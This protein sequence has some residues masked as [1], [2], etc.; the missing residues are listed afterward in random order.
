[1]AIISTLIVTA[2]VTAVMAAGA[3][4]YYATDGFGAGNKTKSSLDVQREREAAKLAEQAA[5][6]A[7]QAKRAEQFTRKTLVRNN[8]YYTP[9]KQKGLVNT[10]PSYATQP[11]PTSVTQPT[12]ATLPTLQTGY[13]WQEVSKEVYNT[14][15]QA[16]QTKPSQLFVDR[17]DTRANNGPVSAL[18]NTIG[19]RGNFLKDAG[20]PRWALALATLGLSEAYATTASF[21]DNYIWDIDGDG[22][23][24]MIK[25]IAVDPWIEVAEGDATWGQAL[26]GNALNTLN[27]FTEVFDILANPIKGIANNGWQGFLDSFGLGGNGYVVYDW[28]TGNF[29]LDLVAE[30]FSDPFTVVSALKGVANAGAK[31]AKSGVKEIGEQATK[32]VAEEATVRATKVHMKKASRAVAKQA[33]N[34]AEDAAQVTSKYTDDLLR[35]IYDN[36]Q[37]VVTKQGRELATKTATQVVTEGGKPVVKQVDLI[38]KVTNKVGRNAG[39]TTYKASKEFISETEQMLIK[40]VSEEASILGIPLNADTL[41]QIQAGVS[42]YIKGVN[43][44]KVATQIMSSTGIVQ[45]QAR[46]LKAS[47]IA[48]W[49]KQQN[50]VLDTFQEGLNKIALYST[51]PALPILGG[52]L[53]K[54]PLAKG[55]RTGV[56]WLSSIFAKI[57]NNTAYKFQNA[58]ASAMGEL[59]PETYTLLRN[60][61]SW[62]SKDVANVLA[63]STKVAGKKVVEQNRLLPQVAEGAYQRQWVSKLTR[64]TR[65]YKE[66]LRK[67][68]GNLGEVTKRWNNYLAIQYR[69]NA[70][71]Y[72][73]FLQTINEIERKATGNAAYTTFINQIKFNNAI[74][75]A[76]NLKAMLKNPAQREQVKMLASK[77]VQGNRLTATQLKDINPD[78]KIIS[79]DD[80]AKQK[81][82][83]ASNQAFIQTNNKVV[84]QNDLYAILKKELEALEQSQG[85]KGLFADL[86]AAGYEDEVNILIKELEHADRLDQ[87]LLLFRANPGL[88]VPI[89]N[90][91]YNIKEQDLYTALA[92]AFMGLNSKVSKTDALTDIVYEMAAVV[93]LQL[94]CYADLTE[95]ITGLLVNDPDFIA[96]LTAS[97]KLYIDNIPAN[98][99]L[100]VELKNN[101]GVVK[102]I[103]DKLEKTSLNTD[104]F[105]RVDELFNELQKVT[106]KASDDIIILPTEMFRAGMDINDNPSIHEALMR[107]AQGNF[108]GTLTTISDGRNLGTYFGSVSPKK[109]FD[110]HVVDNAQQISN[111]ATTI[112]NRIYHSN[113]TPEAEERIH[114]VWGELLEAF[115][116]NPNIKRD[117]AYYKQLAYILNTTSELTTAQKYSLMKFLYDYA[118][119]SNSG[120]LGHFSSIVFDY[121]RSD[122][123]HDILRDIKNFKHLTNKPVVQ[124]VG[125]DVE[126]AH[127]ILL[128]PSQQRA[129]ADLR[130]II[131]ERDQINKGIAS[132]ELQIK[133]VADA[134]PM[135]AQHLVQAKKL[136]EFYDKEIRAY[137]E[138]IDSAVDHAAISRNLEIARSPEARAFLTDEDIRTLEDLYSG[139][140]DV[141]PEKIKQLEQRIDAYNNTL[142][143]PEVFKYEIEQI[144]VDVDE[145]YN[146]TVESFTRIRDKL[147]KGEPLTE[148]EEKLKAA[149]KDLLKAYDEFVDFMTKPDLTQKELNKL[150][151]NPIYRSKIEA[152]RNQ[153]DILTYKGML[154]NAVRSAFIHD[155]NLANQTHILLE[156]MKGAGGYTYSSGYRIVVGTPNLADYDNMKFTFRHEAVHSALAHKPIKEHR[157]IVDQFWNHLMKGE[158][159]DFVKRL[160]AATWWTYYGSSPHYFDS[161]VFTWT[162]TR[163]REEVMNNLIAARDLASPADKLNRIANGY[164]ERIGKRKGVVN[165]VRNDVNEKAL[166]IL[167]EDTAQLIDTYYNKLLHDTAK[168]SPNHIYR[169]P[170]LHE[171]SRLEINKPYLLVG[172][173]MHDFRDAAHSRNLNMMRKRL[174]QS[175]E[176]F[177][178][179]LAR[180]GPFQF[181]SISA[182]KAAKGDYSL[183]KYFDRDMKLRPKEYA[184]LQDAGVGIEVIDEM[185]TVLFYIKKSEVAFD[186]GTSYY[187]RNRIDYTPVEFGYNAKQWHQIDKAGEAFNNAAHE[188]AGQTLGY[189]QGFRI[190][191]HFINTLFNGTQDG[192]SSEFPSWIGL[193]N[194]KK[195]IGGWTLEDFVQGSQLT[196]KYYSTYRFNEMLMGD[197]SYARRF[198]AYYSSNPMVN[199]SNALQQMQM[200]NKTKMEMTTLFFDDTF[201]IKNGIWGDYLNFP[202]SPRPEQYADY[203]EYSKAWQLYQK[204]QQLY[205][206]KLIEYKTKYKK[207]YKHFKEYSPLNLDYKSYEMDQLFYKDCALYELYQAHPEYAFVTMRGKTKKGALVEQTTSGFTKALLGADWNPVR[208]QEFIPRSVADIAKAREIGA[209]FVPR[210]WYNM[211]Y[212]TI[213]NRIGSGGILK[214][215]NRYNFVYKFFTLAS[216]AMTFV[217]NA[218]DTYLKNMLELDDETAM[219]TAYSWKLS[220][221]YQDINRV[222]LEK[223]I[224]GD[225]AIQ[226]FF[227]SGQAKAFTRSGAMTYEMY[228][229][230]RHYEAWGPST[231]GLA[232][233]LKESA[234]TGADTLSH[235]TD[236]ELMRNIA[237]EIVPGYKGVWETAVDMTGKIFDIGNNTIGFRAE[238]VNR[239]ALYMKSLSEGKTREQAFQ[240]IRKVHFDYSVRSLYEQASEVLMPFVTFTTKNLEYWLRTIATEPW[241]AKYLMD[242]FQTQFVYYDFTP[243]QM[244][245]SYQWQNM[246]LSGNIPLWTRESDEFQAYFKLNPSFADAFNT[247]INPIEVA[248][249]RLFFPTRALEKTFTTDYKG[250][251]LMGK[252]DTWNQVLDWTSQLPGNALAR[253]ITNALKQP[254]A[255]SMIGEASGAIGHTNMQPYTPYTP[256]NYGYRTKIKYVYNNNDTYYKRLQSTPYYRTKDLSKQIQ[257]AQM[258]RQI[259]RWK[260]A[261]NTTAG[262]RILD[263]YRPMGQRLAKR[264]FF[265]PYPQMK[266]SGLMPTL[267][268]KQ[269]RL[270][271]MT[272]YRIQRSLF[273]R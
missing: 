195:D 15:V 248:K 189:S 184:K 38:E 217:R 92:D 143:S 215:I 176:D 63:D 120:L 40:R 30:I 55:F 271:S 87:A 265:K 218:F 153:K 239:L 209:R 225:K 82:T 34:I 227:E 188:I 177:A 133:N 41:S 220:A 196:P 232:D 50:M 131:A 73:S 54:T 236:D 103:K 166:F 42:R 214:W 39:K 268:T 44:D 205:N 158:N 267:N 186:H 70:T 79:A 96:N 204:Q 252:Q 152:H 212:N 68:S 130:D 119:E 254:D 250:Q 49:F 262:K 43:F 115:R 145:G 91:K 27:G 66:L 7:E 185:D 129:T 95:D 157:R 106:A 146:G 261:R 29:G 163:I 162:H 77:G 52:I 210:S 74:I 31:A 14:A 104:L 183:F 258:G 199:M 169:M 19:N 155:Y 230:L 141:D 1:M 86:I 249:N 25:N 18:V 90:S 102:G 231:Q 20:I 11:T 235:L 174:S 164:G 272:Q 197:Y 17:Y 244:A 112:H 216:N 100:I 135:L 99:P 124:G 88:Y 65:Y 111:G 241:V 56:D 114:T 161:N 200:I 109:Y 121:I 105:K 116:N 150:L 3:T 5:L 9:V 187:R 26:L 53:K 208:L 221:D 16:Q 21:I 33:A 226:E 223:G 101:I 154:P 48:G 76:N 269:K 159:A 257:Y 58:V 23:D 80:Y 178:K 8:R 125:L 245:A 253:R 142:I 247:F 28:D 10:R 175:A 147:K 126:R 93:E 123:Q 213:N 263:P 256:R 156:Y 128:T 259:N 94:K 35:I 251:S 36:G 13:R 233:A 151:H 170:A 59:T 240:W 75:E 192:F 138:L 246:I 137:Q 32:E 173:I 45:K 84:V 69:K 71:E 224:H 81:T 144:L 134:D 201:S 60:T 222:L 191:E 85:N 110:R 207:D 273:N 219:W 243:E 165:F 12:I 132:L 107:A 136:Q 24:S 180:T 190:D 266:T 62:S 182:L 206:T 6:Q 237:K 108:A 193:N 64:D 89:T 37:Q 228:H 127:R 198:G 57:T 97:L 122:G 179:D 234:I 181:Y 203:A 51:A 61:F 171:G 255:L 67:Y 260:R 148:A 264:L 22:T 160:Y 140:T 83:L 78:I 113:F 211:M 270:F 47:K 2:I 118:E 242:Y 202:K 46:V 167:D 172:Q 194:I 117:N 98:K 139:V 72:L 238:K 168:A 149:Y 4:T 229:D